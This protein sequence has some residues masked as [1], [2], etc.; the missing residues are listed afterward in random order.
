MAKVRIDQ[1]NA[2]YNALNVMPLFFDEIGEMFGF[3]EDRIPYK[4]RKMKLL[5]Y[6]VAYF[7][8]TF[9]KRGIYFSIAF[10]DNKENACFA[11]LRVIKK[12]PEIK[13]IWKDVGNP[14][15][16]GLVAGLPRGERLK[17]KREL[18]KMIH[19]K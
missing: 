7:K 11:L 15:L 4:L 1:Y 13:M 3:E 5:G 10:I 16:G 18:L 9:G 8:Y 17:T 12:F 14:I 2:I 19:Q 6:N